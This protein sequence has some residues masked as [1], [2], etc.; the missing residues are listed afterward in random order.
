MNHLTL[1]CLLLLLPSASSASS[2]SSEQRI[3]IGWWNLENAFDT[4][5]NVD[6]LPQFGTDNEFTPDSAK[7]WD[8][9]KYEHKLKNLA[10]AILSMND[11]KGPDILGVCEVE[12]GHVLREL[13]DSNMPNRKYDIAYHESPDARGIDV[14]FIYDAGKLELLSWG[15]RSVQ[16]PAGDP[17]TRDVVFVEFAMGPHKIVC[18]GNHWP[19]RRGG[20]AESVGKRISAA[21]TCR[22]IVDSVLALHP[23][24]D[25][26]VMGDFNDEPADVSM[27]QYLKATGDRQAASGSTQLYNCMAQWSSDTTR[28]S[29]RYRGKWNLLDQ[30]ILSPGL[31]D[32]DGFDFED[33]EIYSPEFLKEKSGRYAGSPFP[34]Y[35]GNRYL[36]GYS[37][38]FPIVLR[39][40][41]DK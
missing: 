40:N 16:M 27:T 12:H 6:R 11:G 24:A 1:S 3:V 38:H 25:I 15:Y 22:A 28:G 36:G 4:I 14:G 17:P 2:P 21:T 9:E 39:L 35:G 37:D 23:S 34:T 20:N 41:V 33:V 31:F 7:Q 18:I 13:I 26:V 32:K 10:H 30:F 5:D 8:A 19:S 29:Y